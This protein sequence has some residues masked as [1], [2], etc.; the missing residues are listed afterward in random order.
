MKT[1]AWINNDIL[2]EI[3]YVITHPS[4]NFN[5]GLAGRALSDYIPQNR[6]YNYI[7]I[8]YC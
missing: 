5:D 1:K 7:P 3:W 2:I 4:P 8:L 6:V